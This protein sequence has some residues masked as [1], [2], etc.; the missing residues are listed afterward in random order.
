MSKDW[1]PGH[2]AFDFLVF[3]KVDTDV[4]LLLQMNVKVLTVFS[5]LCV[6]SR[7]R[8]FTTHGIFLA[9]VFGVV[10]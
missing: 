10:R 6:L 2:G 9:R 4:H 7:V 5:S 8:L 3:P 1:E